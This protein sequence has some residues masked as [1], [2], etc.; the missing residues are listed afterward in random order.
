MQVIGLVAGANLRAHQFGGRG[1]EV[2]RHV[3]FGLVARLRWNRA[4]GVGTIDQNAKTKLA[5]AGNGHANRRAVV[6]VDREAAPRLAVV[7]RAPEFHF[8]DAPRADRLQ[9]VL[10]VERP[11]VDDPRRLCGIG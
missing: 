6:G 11:S 10:D 5:C 7:G 4:G 9:V 3:E 2:D 8:R 1:L